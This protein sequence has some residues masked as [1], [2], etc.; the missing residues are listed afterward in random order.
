L[1]AFVSPI[2][3]EVVWLLILFVRYAVR[4]YYHSAQVDEDVEVL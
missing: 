2:A 1:V 3:A 4:R